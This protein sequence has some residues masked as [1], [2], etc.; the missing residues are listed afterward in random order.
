[1]IGRIFWNGIKAFVPIAMTISIVLWLFTS[2]EAFFGQYIRQHIPPEYYFE[3]LGIIVGVLLIFMLGLLVNAWMVRKIYQQADT[4]V[5][6]IPFIKTIYNA[7]Q[8]LLNFFDKSNQSAQQAVMVQTKF[9]KVMGFVTKDVLTTMTPALGSED[10]VLV[11]I[12]LS[13]M[14]GGIATVVPRKAITPLDWS[15]NEAMSFI[16][17]AGMTGAKK[18]V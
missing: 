5:K 1:M 4:I 8:D 7:I 13:Y 12:P 11:Y 2:I 6:K 17:T 9:G 16:L 10:E 3:G 15:V 14:V 18:N